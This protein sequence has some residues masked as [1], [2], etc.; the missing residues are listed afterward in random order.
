MTGERVDLQVL[1]EYVGSAPKD[2][3][4]FAQLAITSLAAALAPVA[5]AMATGDLRTLQASGHRAKS[6]AVHI[7][8][9]DFADTCRALEEAARLGQA[10][11]ALA[12]AGQLQTRFVPLEQALAR[13]LE[14][15]LGRSH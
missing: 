10:E 9:Q 3:R 11:Q 13:A 14:L 4:H 2:L 5:Q 1:E 6:T 7:G 12:L 15:R 8:A